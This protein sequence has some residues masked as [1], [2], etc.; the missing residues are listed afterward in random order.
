MDF[1]DTLRSNTESTE[2]VLSFCLASAQPRSRVRAPSIV[3]ARYINILCL[4]SP[5]IR[6]RPRKI[7]FK[8]K[9]VDY[10]NTRKQINLEEAVARFFATI[11]HPPSGRRTVGSPNGYSMLQVSHQNLQIGDQ[12]PGKKG[13]EGVSLLLVFVVVVFLGG[14]RVSWWFV[15][16]WRIIIAILCE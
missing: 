10:I 12:D 5:K 9:Q 8:G 3:R 2:I 11:A 1:D 14:E 16:G 7:D 15:G 13:G 6:V 4:C